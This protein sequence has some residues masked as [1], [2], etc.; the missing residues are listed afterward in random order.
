MSLKATDVQTLEILESWKL[1]EKKLFM[2]FIWENDS[3]SLGVSPVQTV[4]LGL[5][6][7]L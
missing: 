4:E 1:Q 6:T 2:F 5:T 3:T 7:I